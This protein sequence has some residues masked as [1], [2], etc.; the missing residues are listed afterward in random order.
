MGI[1]CNW[2]SQKLWSINHDRFQATFHKEKN[3]RYIF[4]CFL[5]LKTDLSLN[6]SKIIPFYPNKQIR[7]FPYTCILFLG[8]SGR[9]SKDTAICKL[10][11]SHNYLRFLMLRPVLANAKR[12]K[13]IRSQRKEWINKWIKKLFSNSK[14][15]S[16]GQKSGSSDCSSQSLKKW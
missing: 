11:F 14:S 16:I 6:F 8:M 5:K 2:I 15:V 12:E 3:W 10:A 7:T 1:F 13:S 4:T 9:N